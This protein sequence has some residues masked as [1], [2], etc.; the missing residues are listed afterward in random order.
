[1]MSSIPTMTSE[2]IEATLDKLFPNFA[3]RKLQRETILKALNYMLIQGKKYVI[4]DGPVGSGKSYIAYIIAKVYNYILGEETLFLTKTILLQD[5]YL[6]DFKD[7]V[8]LMGAE[9][10]EC[11]VDYYVPIVPKLK[12]HKTCKYTKNSGCCEY[13]KAKAQYQNSKLKLLNYAFYTKGIDT[14]QSSGLVI[15]DEA[16]NFEESL[17]S[18]LGMDLDLVQFRDLCYKHLDK[19]LQE[20]FDSPLDQIKKLSPVDVQ[21][22]ANFAGICMSIVSKQIEDIEDSLENSDIDNQSLLR[23]LEH[24]LDPL[25][26]L[27][28]NISYYGLR[29][30]IMA[31]SDLE[32]FSIYYQEKDP[33]AKR[34]YF[35]IKPVFIP[36]VVRSMIFGKPSNMIFMSGTAERI[37]DSLK[38]PDEETA[39]ITN[40]YL[41]PLDN[42]PFYAFTNLPKLNVD[43]FDEV[44]PR[45]CTITDGIIEQYPEDTNVIIHS[46]SYKNAEFYKEHSKLKDRI[47]IPTSKEVKDLTNLIKPGMIVVSPS[48]TEGVDLGDGL[49]KVQIFMKCPYPYL[50]DLWVKKKM[51][52]DQGWYSYATLLAIIQG[53]G[54]GIRSATDQADTFC[55]DPSFKGLLMRNGEYVPDWFNKSIKFIDL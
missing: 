45:Y 33:N 8:K 42:R 10:Y 17:L 44:F 12:H 32:T 38:L 21:N 11:S 50:G 6:R 46:V 30:S 26:R 27:Q 39:T 43:T 41:F 13:A 53:S 1:M 25:K 48:I 15:C 40:P 31:Q 49:A 18:M 35:Q 23:I 36:T 22:L 54:R 29:L 16:H 52:L 7:I 20:R 19:D 51:E 2:M 28:D 24:E 14:Y 5:Q 3:Y 47:F 9:N 37:K 34:P 4:V 55:L